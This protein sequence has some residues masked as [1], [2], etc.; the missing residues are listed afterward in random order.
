MDLRS[1]VLRLLAEAS[2]DSRF[3]V[4]YVAGLARAAGCRPHELQEVLWGLVG[5]G[6]AYLDTA[7]QPSSDNWSWRLS[8]AG[9]QAAAGGEWEPRDPPGYLRRLSRD[10]PDLSPLALPYVEEALRA[11]NAR[12]YL[13]ASVMLGVASEAV[14][15]DLAAAFV[16]AR[17]ADADRLRRLLD[18]RRST[19]FAQFQEFRKRLEPIRVEL[20]EHLGDILTLDA[21]ADLLRV[22]RNAAGHPSGATVDEDTARTHLQMAAR[23]LGR[24][25]ALSRHF[26]QAAARESAPGS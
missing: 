1:Q 22:T 14:F 5:E 23:Y 8:A 2:T 13:A 11:F 6:L 10:V 15:A 25:T 16:R 3:G 17:G 24:M 26:D 4:P 20:P 7:G 12:C 21:V 9:R 19:H 18:D